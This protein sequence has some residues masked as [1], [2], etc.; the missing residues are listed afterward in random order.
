MAAL[1]PTTQLLSCHRGAAAALRPRPRAARPVPRLA[2]AAPRRGRLACRAQQKEEPHSGA[3]QHEEAGA[4]EQQSFKDLAKL[5]AGAAPCASRRLRY[6]LH[7]ARP[8]QAS[9]GLGWSGRALL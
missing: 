4:L 9:E 2:P 3:G 1:R 6:V 7:A 5:V 8:G